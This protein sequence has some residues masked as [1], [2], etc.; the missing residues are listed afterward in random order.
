MKDDPRSLDPREVRLLSDINLIKHLYEGLVQEIPGTEILEPALAKSY[1]ISQDR[2]TYT[3][4]LREA[5]WSNGDRIQAQDFVDSWKQIITEEI[6]SIYTFALSPIKNVNNIQK[7]L[8]ELDS[9]GFY[10]KDDTTII[11]ELEEAT[12]H[13]LQL[14]ALPIFFPVHKTQR[15][16][17]PN[18]PITT[19]AFYPKK[20]KQK[21]W[22]KLAKNPHYYNKDK[23]STQRITIHFIPDP[24]TA[25]LMFNQGK[26]HWQG[27]PWGQPIPKETLAHLQSKGHL[28][29]FDV[30]GTSWLTF[31]VNTPPLN[32]IKLRKALSLAIDKNALVSTIFLDKAKP[33]DHLLPR[34]LHT[35]PASNIMSQQER[36]R[37]AKQL[38]QEALQELG[39]CSKDLENL[40]IIF[41]S[42]SPTNALLVQMIREQWKETLG[43]VIPIFGK[44]FSVL[45]SDLS[46]GNFFLATGGWFADFPDP[47]AFLTIF[48]DPFGIAPYVIHQKEFQNLIHTIQKE[49]DP[50]KRA[51]MISEAA[52][53]LEKFHII[54]P[55]YHDAIQCAFHRKLNNLGFSSTGVVDF[56]YIREP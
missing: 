52:L 16:R 8:A 48:A 36:V 37:L 25:A 54:E 20:I 22:L 19:S 34:N 38:F 49:T 30:L 51:I 12:A 46:S 56:R 26:L 28:H 11:I 40:S 23:V 3:F 7:G 39:I 27:P 35:Y 1:E 17:S 10:A 5:F 13:F 31:N 21:Q 47:M 55:I 18:L 53:Y 44:E 15:Q 33:T 43:F 32:H 45:Q 14:L 4:K 6:S 9:V 42:T 50:Q 2:K 29:S 24:N 41:P